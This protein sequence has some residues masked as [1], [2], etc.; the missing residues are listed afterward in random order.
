V[1][2]L[3]EFAAEIADAGEALTELLAHQIP[4][5]ELGLA[6]RHPVQSQ[7]R[8]FNVVCRLE[9]LD[10]RWARSGTLGGDWLPGSGVLPESPP[11]SWSRRES[12]SVRQPSSRKGAPNRAWYRFSWA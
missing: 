2:R 1:Q 3:E 10:L 4:G 8:G 5:D 6:G 12:N 11:L 9:R 7:G